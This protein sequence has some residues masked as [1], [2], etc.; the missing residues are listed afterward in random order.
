MYSLI[1]KKSTTPSQRHTILLKLNKQKKLPVL[2]QRTIFLKNKAGRNNVGRITVFKK[3]GGC[4]KKYRILVN[5]FYSGVVENL[6]YDP[7]R[8]ANIARIFCL[9]KK[10][11]FYVIAAENL[12]RGY[13][14]ESQ[15]RKVENFNF[16]IGNLFFLKNIPLGFFVFNVSFPSK[17]SWLARSAG[18]SAQVISKNDKYCRLRLKSG[19]HRLFLSNT[20]V[21]LGIASNF[22]HKHILLG[23]AGRSRWLNKRPS[24]RGVAMNSVDHPHGG[25]KNRAKTPWGKINKGISTSKKIKSKFV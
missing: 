5:S 24:V 23:K 18:S 16:K 11:H 22:L 20:K 10:T 4:K 7:Y 9:E 1:Y 2:K 19:E 21:F 17:K 8:S 14:I 15:L 3:G 25:G 6:E 13:F 12:K